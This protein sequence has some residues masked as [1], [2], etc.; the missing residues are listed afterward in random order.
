MLCKDEDEVNFGRFGFPGLKDGYLMFQGTV[1]GALYFIQGYV[2]SSTQVT[3]FANKASTGGEPIVRWHNRLGHANVETI[4]R[5]CRADAVDGLILK[6]KTLP[7]E[8]CPDCTL[9]KMFTRFAKWNPTLASNVGDVVHRDLCVP[10]SVD[11]LA[12]SRYFAIYV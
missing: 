10:M 11:S 12:G 3:L 8:K 1:R 5:L 6:N 9:G 2:N 7:K 4:R